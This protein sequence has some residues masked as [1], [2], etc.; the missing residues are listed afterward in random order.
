MV[1]IMF[2][3][4]VAA[5]ITCTSSHA[6]VAQDRE[7]VEWPSR[8]FPRQTLQQAVD[9]VIDGGT[10]VIA[11]G[12]HLI[13]DPVWIDKRVDLIGAG[14]SFEIPD[15]EDLVTRLNAGL[16]DATMREDALSLLEE[17][18]L[19]V[20]RP[21]SSFSRLKARHEPLVAEIEDAV[22]TVN[23][24]GPDAGG[25]IRDVEFAGG[26]SA[27]IVRG[28]GFI[29]DGG[30]ELDPGTPLVIQ[31][32]CIHDTVRGMAVL[33]PKQI[34]VANT[35]V[36]NVLWNGFSIV[37]PGTDTFGPLLAGAYFKNIIVSGTENAC[38]LWEN[39]SGAI[40][41]FVANDCEA[42]GLGF[43]NSGVTMGKGTIIGNLGPGIG[44]FDSFVTVDRVASFV[45]KLMGIA[46]FDSNIGIEK[47]SIALTESGPNGFLG[48]GVVAVST[49]GVQAPASINGSSIANNDRAGL[50]N[51]GSN[52]SLKDT[53]FR[54][55]PIDITGHDL[56]FLGFHFD[57]L[58]GNT[59]GCPNPVHECVADPVQ[60]TPPQAIPPDP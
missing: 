45:N 44:V 54:C 49:Q 55:N 47:S 15:V 4:L 31:D 48:D 2:R 28:E 21:G 3:R 39:A 52:I 59:C 51:I 57:D 30:A 41:D 24:V 9:N 12:E 43:V 17:N 20:P 35:I 23:Y 22:A 38:W 16:L 58:G 34:K 25:M 56:G 13:L 18:P 29:R 8:E 46:A 14:C 50:S 1:A 33:A 5:A 40:Y 36:F 7:V 32:S 6:A 26:Q 60:F 53:K 37:N 11:S 10:V 19:I 42:M 27:V